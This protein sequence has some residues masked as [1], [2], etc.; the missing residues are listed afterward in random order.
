M[1]AS[2]RKLLTLALL[3]IFSVVHYGVASS[4]LL[5]S[6]TPL[7]VLSATKA[8][9][10]LIFSNSNAMDEDPTGLAVGSNNPTS[11]SEIARV[12]ARNLVANYTGRINMG[13]MAY[14]QSSVVHQWLNQSPYD[15]SFDP[16]TYDPAWT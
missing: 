15:A 8:N 3:V 11:K 2:K 6:Q 9:V 13:L 4:T 14:Q 5:I 16:A 12:A 1:K 10:L 7:F